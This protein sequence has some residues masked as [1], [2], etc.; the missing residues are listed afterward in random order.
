MD[1][2]SHIALS[3][4]LLKVCGEPE[5]MGYLSIVPKIDAS[6]S[7]LHR[8]H[9][10]PLSKG[11]ILVKAALNVFGSTDNNVPNLPEDTFELVRL[12]EEYSS[13]VE[14]FKITDNKDADDMAFK[15]GYGALLSVLSH[16]YFDT[17]NNAVQAF[18][19]YESYCAGQYDMWSKVDYF[20]YR[21][22]WYEQTAPEVREKVLAE[23]FW[24]VEF[25]AKEMVKGIIHRVAALTKPSIKPETI[26]QVEKDLNV[27]DV[28]F[29]PEVEKFYIKLEQSLEKNLIHSVQDTVQS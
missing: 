5:N 16:S 12:K 22:K 6:P 24:K 27:D 19:P 29:N 17:Y 1:R 15:Y 2:F 10:H 28:P 8:L 14:D 4:G 3:K 7:F 9:C 23:E 18:A 13:F 11:P 26:K 20:N 21:I 25:S